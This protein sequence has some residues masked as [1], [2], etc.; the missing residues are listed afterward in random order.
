MEQQHTSCVS[1]SQVPCPFETCEGKTSVS[2][3][4]RFCFA[5][6][7]FRWLFHFMLP[8]SQYLALTTAWGTGSHI[9]DVPWSVN[10][11]NYSLSENGPV[12]NIS[13][14]DTDDSWW[15]NYTS[16]ELSSMYIYMHTIWSL[17]S[18]INSLNVVYLRQQT[19][20]TIITAV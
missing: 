7:S 5:D 9:C 8:Y 12:F 1:R 11:R 17:V 10:S 16:S 15:Y 19:M 6:C 3:G 18:G 4:N 13:G 2:I 20:C 14:F